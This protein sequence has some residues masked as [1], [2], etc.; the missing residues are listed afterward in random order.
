ML[1][2]IEGL[3]SIIFF[4]CLDLIKVVGSVIEKVWIRGK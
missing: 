2:D 4:V 1:W 3:N